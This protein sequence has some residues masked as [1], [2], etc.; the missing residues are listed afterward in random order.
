ME[1]FGY[2]ASL[3]PDCG[4][5]PSVATRLLREDLIT[6]GQHVDHLVLVYHLVVQGLLLLEMQC[7]TIDA[8]PVVIDPGASQSIRDLHAVESGESFDAG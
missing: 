5:V 4:G 7:R 3:P 6:N 1:K 8:G 2:L